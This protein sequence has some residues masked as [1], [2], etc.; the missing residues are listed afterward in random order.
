MPLKRSEGYNEQK[1]KQF[2]CRSR[3]DQEQC[4]HLAGIIHPHVCRVVVVA[5]E[6]AIV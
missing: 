2:A 4:R 6:R 3:R 1:E 5:P